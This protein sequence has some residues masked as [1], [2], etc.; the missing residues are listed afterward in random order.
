MRNIQKYTCDFEWS[1]F[2]AGALIEALVQALV[3]AS[4]ETLAPLLYVQDNNF[5]NRKIVETS[6]MDSVS[7]WLILK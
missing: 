2:L 6:P 4:I 7:V 1:G 3:E 5:R